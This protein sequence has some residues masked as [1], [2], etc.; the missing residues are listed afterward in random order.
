MSRAGEF[1]LSLPYPNRCGCC[2][3]RIAWN[4]LLC[5][6]CLRT[7]GTLHITPQDWLSGHAE[8][9]FPWERLFTVFSYCSAARAG[10][11]AMKDGAENFGRFAGTLLAEQIRAAMPPAEIDCV[12]WVPVSAIRRHR[13]GY[14][15]AEMLGRRIAELLG[16]TASGRLLRQSDSPLRQHQLRASER[17]VFSFNFH[18]TNADLSGQTVLLADDV[19]TTGSTMRRCTELLL[20]MGAARVFAAAAACRIRQDQGTDQGGTDP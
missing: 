5:A 15:H 16:I 1:L 11:L 19:L 13:Q 6:D 14:A 20:E 10:I 3:R 2:R 4:I 9:A 7:L 18:R 8:E 12:T 17:A